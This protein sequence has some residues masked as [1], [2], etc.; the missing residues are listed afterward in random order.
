MNK[1]FNRILVPVSFNRNSSLVMEKAI[2]VANEF[3]C[4]MHLLHAQTPLMPI[5][6]VYDGFYL[7]ARNTSDTSGAEE[8]MEKLRNE[9]RHLLNDDLNLFATVLQGNWEKILKEYIISRHIDLTI[10]PRNDRLFSPSVLNE[11]NLDRLAHQTHC[12]ILTLTQQFDIS[13][14]YNIVVPV[15]HFLPVRKL[16]VATFLACRFHAVVHLVG[17]NDN[18]DGE[19]FTNS[20]CVAK[21]YQLVT[22]YSPVKIHYPEEAGKPFAARI[23]KYAQKLK[24][25][26]IVVNPGGE[27][28]LWRW[29]SGFLGKYLYRESRIPVLT[30]SPE[31]N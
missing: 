31:M 24:A 1:F 23:L 14:L 10:I 28:K 13:H 20:L 30:I 16:S 4:D 17:H 22:K 18:Y 19:D 12:P 29:F 26:L 27:T 7:P 6:Y 8:K 9:Y 2:Q 25:D 21:S 5:P 3:N 11:I 15:D